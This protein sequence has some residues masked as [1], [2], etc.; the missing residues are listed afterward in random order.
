MMYD[1][2]TGRRPYFPIQNEDRVPNKRKRRKTGSRSTRLPS[3]NTQQLIRELAQRPGWQAELVHAYLRHKYNRH[4]VSLKMIRT[5]LAQE[6][7]RP[8]S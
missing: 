7:V 8:R 2:D 6:R 4:D 1:D 5:V 3:A